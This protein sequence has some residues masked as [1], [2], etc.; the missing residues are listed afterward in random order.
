VCELGTRVLA[1]PDRNG[2]SSVEKGHRSS[3]RLWTPHE[4]LAAR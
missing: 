4:A 2:K 3:L 1:G